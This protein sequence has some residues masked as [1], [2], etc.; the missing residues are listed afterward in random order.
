MLTFFADVSKISKNM[1]HSGGTKLLQE[2]SDNLM[3]SFI[4][5]KFGKRKLN[6]RFHFSLIE[7]TYSFRLMDQILET[8]KK[9]LM[10]S[11]TR[12]AFFF[13]SHKSTSGYN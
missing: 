1:V 4:D 11:L 3:L 8:K 12:T 5:S 2:N 6:A 9:D 13:L 7:L 10:W